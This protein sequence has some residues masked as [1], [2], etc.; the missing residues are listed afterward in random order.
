MI[1][2]VAIQNPGSELK[3]SA[4]TS[5]EIEKDKVSFTVSRRESNKEFQRAEANKKLGPFVINHFI[6]KA[7]SWDNC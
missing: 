1:V 7:R 6:S 4:K 5:G 2:S 3:L